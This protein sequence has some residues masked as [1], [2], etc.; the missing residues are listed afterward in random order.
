[1][2]KL[3]AIIARHKLASVSSDRS[4]TAVKLYRKAVSPDWFRSKPHILA[5]GQAL[6]ARSQSSASKPSAARRP[7]DAGGPSVISAR[8]R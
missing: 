6:Q 1:M 5:A 8:R 4:I 2:A 7:P 3:A